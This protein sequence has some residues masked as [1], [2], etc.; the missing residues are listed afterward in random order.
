MTTPE[1]AGQVALVTGGTRGIG[2]AIALELARLGAD[3]LLNFHS[4]SESAERCVQ[5]IEALGQRAAALRADI[6]LQSE[7]DRLFGWVAERGGLDILVNCAGITR[8]EWFLTMRP[9]SWGDVIA[10]HL[11][12]SLDCSRQAFALMR[13]RARG[14]IFLIGSGAC[15]G[16]RPSQSNYA[17]AKSALI[18]LNRA[19]AREAAPYGI[20]VLLVAPGFTETD[21]SALVAEDTASATKR[22][23]PLGRWGRSD[24]IA[25]WVGFTASAAGAYF[26]GT[27]IRIDGGRGVWEE[28]DGLEY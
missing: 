13:R 11:V 3:V 18:G 4:D 1:L 23:I 24:E 21:M 6:A 15:F 25:Q 16:P 9:R 27:A 7:R 17:T 26:T 19:L 20:R 8:D 2:R 10:T 22:I 14:V 5:L 12:G 28:D